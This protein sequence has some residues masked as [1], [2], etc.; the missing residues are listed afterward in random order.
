MTDITT[1][2]PLST[3]PLR[4]R[5]KESISEQIKDMIY[6][7]GLR[8]GDRLP[9]ERELMQLFRASKGSVRE[10]LSA[11]RSQGLIR[12]RT[13]PGGGVFLSEIDPQRAMALMSNYFLFRT[14]TI[15]DIYE[16][17][18]ELEPELAATLAGRLSEADFARLERT[19]RLYDAPPATAEEEY[20]Q[21]LAELD[22]HSVLAD[23]CPNPVLGL[24]CRFLQTLLRE[25]V[26]CRRIYDTPHPV[27][28]DTAIHYQIR[29]LRALRAGDSAA[30]REIMAGHMAAAQEYMVRMEASIAGRFLRVQDSPG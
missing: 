1:Q 15:T 14:P 13:G 22:F 26:V 24:F 9:A 6:E 8:P 3:S 19:M 30:A 4:R 23:L 2:D 29:L 12:T 20:A 16:V 21:R 5:R 27:L 17:R 18:C 7:R 25:T 11:L 10:A 28:R